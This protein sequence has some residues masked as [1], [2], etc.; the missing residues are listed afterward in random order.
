MDCKSI[1]PKGLVG[2]RGPDYIDNFLLRNGSAKSYI[3]FRVNEKRDVREEVGSFL[4][5]ALD[6]IVV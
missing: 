3:I 6:S 4:S 2:F 5:V 1:R